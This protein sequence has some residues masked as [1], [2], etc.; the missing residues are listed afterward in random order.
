MRTARSNYVRL[1]APHIGVGTRGKSRRLTRALVDFGV[2]DSF[3]KANERLREHYGFGLNASAVREATLIHAARAQA[4]LEAQYGESFR[5]LP[6]EGA[7]QLVAQSD[8]SMVCTVAGGPR[9]APRP[10]EWKEMRLM[11]AQRHGSVERVY[12]A[13]FLDVGE[14][15]RR[16]GHCARD[17]GWGFNSRVHVIGDGAPWIEIQSREVFGSQGSFLLDFYHASEYLG[18]AAPSCRPRNPRSWRRTQQRRLRTGRCGKLMDELRDHCE[19]EAVPEESAPVR[20]A[21]RYLGNRIGQLDYAGAL[22]KE[23]PIGS[24]MIESG[25]RHLIQSRLKKPGSAWLPSSAHAIVQLR[26]LR[27]N[28]HWTSLWN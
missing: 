4:R 1:L 10:R 11:A 5:I 12:A 28:G 20:T 7:G 9:K 23:L 27:A 18:A 15:G 25:H 16:W 14:A 22:A 3:A 24:G 21:L 6:V 2:E 13:G 17:A 26:V 8:G 19:P